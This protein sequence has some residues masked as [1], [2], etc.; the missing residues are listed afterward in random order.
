MSIG[1]LLFVKAKI[2]PAVIA[3][4]N[5]DEPPYDKNGKVIPFV[6]IRS[7]LLAIWIND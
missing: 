1:L 5:K 3:E 4:A 2:I 7:V 6:G